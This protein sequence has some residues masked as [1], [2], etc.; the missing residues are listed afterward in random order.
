[1]CGIAGFY[2]KLNNKKSIIANQ[3]K[4]LNHRGPD[5]SGLYVKGNIAFGHA[6]LAIIDIANAKQPMIS[7]DEHY[8][9]TFNGEIYNYLELRQHLTSMGYKFRTHSDTE[10]L[11]FMYSEYG[12][13]CLKMLNGM[14]AFA[15][16]DTIK[17]VIF[18]ARDHFGIKPLYYISNDDSFIFASEIK[19]ILQ[20]PGIKAEPDWKSVNEYLTFQ[21]MLKKHTLFKNIYTLEPATYI[22][23]KN[24]NIIE[25]NTYWDIDFTVDDAKSSEQYADELLV[26][27]EN[28]L[29]L[30]IRSDVPVGAHLS[31]G[32]DSSTVAILASNNY[33]GNIQTFT[34]GF[35]DSSDYDETKYAKLVSDSIKSNHHEIFPTSTD[36]VDSFQKLI[37]HMDYPEA[38]PGLFPQYMVSK[39]ASNHVKVVLGGQGGDEVFGGY[40]RYTVAYLE[41]AL[42]G[43]IFETKEEGQHI[44]TLASIIPN[45]PQLRKY[46]PLISDQFSEG[47]F[48]PMD[49]R[50]FRMINRSHKLGSIFNA[51]FL[52]TMNEKLM[53]DKFKQVFNHPTTLSYFNKMTHFDIK[54]LLPA[55]LHVE[56]RVS[57][58]VSLESRVPLLDYRIVELAAKMPPTLKFAGGK[59]KSMLLNSV[60]NILPPEI[61]ARKDKMGFPTPINLWLGSELKS[62]ALDILGSKASKERGLLNTK[63][64]EAGINESG[65]FSRDLWG[66]LCLEVW[67]KTFI[68]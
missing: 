24:G 46:L 52:Q 50:Y 32:I 68:D 21:L 29:N 16:Y 47:L 34:G 1:M 31:G 40:T 19:S 9:L 59:A 66:A 56:D 62:Y 55:L 67:F 8:V 61:L 58:A 15:I 10:V 4:V 23:V 28:S 12:K 14:F 44:V 42:K 11:L 39:L 63:T 57:M 2:S 49:E 51:S 41:Q 53:H 37:Y 38:G 26:L 30:Q 33:Y 45:M 60:R 64:I 6:R 20:F 7:Y 27:L 17:D 18:L 3:I 65:Q 13:D 48:G 5:D 35:K 43:A 54:T 25:K 22:V 36:F